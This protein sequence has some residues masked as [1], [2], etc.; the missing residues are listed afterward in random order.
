MTQSSGHSNTRNSN[1]TPEGWA[2]RALL[3]KA[4]LGSLFG[5]FYERFSD[6]SLPDAK[7]VIE[8]QITA[9]Y[10]VTENPPEVT[11]RAMLLKDENI[12]RRLEKQIHSDKDFE[13]LARYYSLVRASVGGAY[14][15][16]EQPE[17]VKLYS[18]EPELQVGISKFGKQGILQVPAPFDRTWLVNILD[19][20]KLQPKKTKTD[21]SFEPSPL[22]KS[23][24]GLLRFAPGDGYQIEKLVQLNANVE[25]LNPNSKLHNPIAVAINNTKFGISSIFAF[26][27]L[28]CLRSLHAQI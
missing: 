27:S 28:E 12:A 26:N 6:K 9:S 24:F 3:E 8:Q 2:A 22:G 7:E 1:Y 18:L 10:V 23:G 25:I 5:E 16:T 13:K 17:S 4:Y 15:G 21:F 11:I 19:T 14:S 20:S